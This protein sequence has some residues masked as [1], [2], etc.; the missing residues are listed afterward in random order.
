MSEVDIE[1]EADVDYPT[2][3]VSR[4]GQRGDETRLPNESCGSGSSR[5]VPGTT[6]KEAH[7]THSPADLAG[8]SGEEFQDAQSTFYDMNHNDRVYNKQE[9]KRRESLQSVPQQKRKGPSGRNQDMN[10]SVNDGFSSGNDPNLKPGGAAGGPM[11][12]DQ[13]IRV[14]QDSA[15]LGDIVF[16]ALE[17][18]QQRQRLANDTLGTDTSRLITRRQ[19]LEKTIQ[20]AETELKQLQDN[21][22]ANGQPAPSFDAVE[23]HDYATPVQPTP[24]H[25]EKQDGPA[26]AGGPVSRDASP[27]ASFD[28]Q[29]YTNSASTKDASRGQITPPRAAAPRRH[30]TYG[31]T[32]VSPDIAES[33]V[34]SSPSLRSPRDNIGTHWSTIGAGEVLG[35][36]IRPSRRPT[37]PRVR[38]NPSQVPDFLER[39]RR[40]YGKSVMNTSRGHVSVHMAEVARVFLEHTQKRLLEAVFDFKYREDGEVEDEIVKAGE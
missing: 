7:E 28:E 23:T 8:S 20:Q 34:R 17:E 31:D 18:Y 4:V 35:A 2:S 12:L 16:R 21:R 14:E 36:S 30:V 9:D 1:K 24:E 26:D 32:F 10:M 38:T 33:V 22:E 19:E 15:K 29:M 6:S 27:R 13:G 3:Q 11:T 39:M 25:D 37:S 5:T 40:V